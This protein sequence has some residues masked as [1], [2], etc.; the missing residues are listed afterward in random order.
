MKAKSPEP[1]VNGTPSRVAPNARKGSTSSTPGDAAHELDRL[2]RDPAERRARSSARGRQEEVGGERLRGPDRDGRPERADHDGDRDHHRERHR[3]RARRRPTCARG[4]PSGSRA[5][6][7][8][9][10]RRGGARARRG[11]PPRTSRRRE[12]AARRP[13]RSGRP[14]GSPKSG[15]P[16]TGPG[17]V[18]RKASD[19]QGDARER[20]RA[21]APAADGLD[22]AVAHRRGRLD[23]RG[24]ERR[25]ERRQD[26]R[27]DAESEREEE[28]ERIEVQRRVRRR[29]VELG[30]GSADEEE[31]GLR[32]ND[33]EADPGGA[34]EDAERRGPRRG[35]PRRPSASTLRARGRSRCRSGASAPRSKACCRRSTC[36]RG[37][38]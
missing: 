32:E 14:T 33:A 17:S 31:R 23:A 25:G 3:E 11:A 7:A 16:R 19:E 2:V 8:P 1:I 34:P 28:D 5:R 18:A 10:R 9:R 24:L 15:R 29:D 27:R 12:R 30:R 4:C 20:E 26:R 37:A 22:R 21:R 6:S 38:R 36:R 35:R 13:R